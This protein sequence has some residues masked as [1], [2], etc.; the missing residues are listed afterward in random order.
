MGEQEA[1]QMLSD[2]VIPPGRLFVSVPEAS[3]ILGLDRE[4][5]TVRKAIEAGEIPAV[6]VGPQWRIPVAWIR[7]QARLSA[8]AAGGPAAA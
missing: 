8:A 7:E 4:G 1:A 6:R 5:R 3:A 2:H